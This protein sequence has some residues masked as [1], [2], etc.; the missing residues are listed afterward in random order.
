MLCKAR[1]QERIDAQ[2]AFLR[3]ADKL[4]SIL[5]HS[6]VSFA[7][8]HEND[9]EHSW[10]LALTVMILADHAEPG[11]DLL[12]TMQMVLMSDI[13]EI[14]AGDTVIDSPTGRYRSIPR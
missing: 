13:V 6:R 14:D 9:A 7:D 4:K 12:R 10:H 2:L 11:L 5:R 8:P 3:E 1:T